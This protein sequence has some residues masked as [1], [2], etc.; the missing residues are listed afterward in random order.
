MS[1]NNRGVDENEILEQALQ[2]EVWEETGVDIS[3][4]QIRALPFI[5]SGVAEKTLKTG[6]KVLCTVEFYRFEI[7]IDDK[8]RMKFNYTPQTISLR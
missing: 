1:I 7:R 6:E 2:R 3:P 8:T 5:G 4:Y